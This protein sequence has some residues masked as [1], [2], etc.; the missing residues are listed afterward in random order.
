M[1]KEAERLLEEIANTMSDIPNVPL[2]LADY[3]ELYDLMFEIQD[4]LAQVATKESV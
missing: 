4:F 2:F 1:E 3:S